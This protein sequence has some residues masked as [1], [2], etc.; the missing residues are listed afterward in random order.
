[1]FPE[2][3]TLL[4]P[5]DILLIVW[6]SVT[7][8]LQDTSFDQA[9]F[10]EAFLVTK[11]FECGKLFPLVIIGFEH[12]PEGSLADPLVDFKSVGNMIVHITDVFTLVV[13]KSS[14]FRT[15]GCLKLT[16]LLALHQVYEI[17]CIVLQYLCL[18]II[19]QTLAEMQERSSRLHRKLYLKLL[20][21]VIHILTPSD[22]RVRGHLAWR[23]WRD[24]LPG[25]ILALHSSQLRPGTG[26]VLVDLRALSELRV[27]LRPHTR[28]CLSRRASYQML[29]FG[30][31]HGRALR[32]APDQV[33]CSDL[34]LSD[35]GARAVFENNTVITGG[36]CSVTD[37]DRTAY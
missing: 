36:N 5:Y 22:S 29:H 20:L 3:Q 2:D 26:L 31:D 35:F 11:N 30:C 9:L 15:I 23:V 7:E 16:T 8:R 24:A 21:A 10:I 18:F 13:V 6:I 32:Y 28:I 14:V 34:R 25:V 37:I 1:M 33:P 27:S 4:N 19:Q 12:L 17:D